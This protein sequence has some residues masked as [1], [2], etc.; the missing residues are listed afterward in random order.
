MITGKFSVYKYFG[1]ERVLILLPA[2]PLHLFFEEMDTL[3]S[4][5]EREGYSEED[6]TEEGESTD[7]FKFI[8]SDEQES[9]KR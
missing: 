5:P 1:I 4:G 6:I 8:D 9:C 7:D 2:P 3:C